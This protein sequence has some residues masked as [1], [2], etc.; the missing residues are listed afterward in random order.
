MPFPL[1]RS[2]TPSKVASFKN[3]ALAF[4]FAQIDKLPQPPSVPAV[5]GT[6]V[7]SVLERLFWELEP[8]ERSLQAG[9]RILADEWRQIQNDEEWAQLT[10]PA[11]E[12]AAF[13]DESEQLVRNYFE[14]EDPNA[15]R[16]VG[17][18]LLLEARVGSLVLRGI[19]DRLDLA[20]D[21]NFIVV[22][23]KT[24]RAPSETYETTKLGGVHFYAYLLQE[25]LGRRPV[26]VRL[27]H[28]K[29]PIALT[30]SSSEQSIKGLKLRTAA[31]WTAVERACEREDFRPK[32][33][34]LCDWCPFQAY[35]PAQGGTLPELAESA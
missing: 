23:Y 18:E 28:L 1:P 9:Q 6:L 26:A 31:V 15:V 4:R 30:C 33:G 32:P 34:R 22:D 20:A 35:C 14:L 7:H 29:E 16:V 17:T 5:R 2:L 21:G 11:P 12:A 10:L 27:L 25:V 19:I 13:L 3:C 24:G 8:G